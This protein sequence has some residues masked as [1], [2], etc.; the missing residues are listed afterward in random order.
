MGQS[1]SQ[2]KLSG[3]VTL[4][5]IRE[6][7]QRDDSIPESLKGFKVNLL[8]NDLNALGFNISTVDSRGHSLSSEDVCRKIKEQAVP[9][10]EEV[11][12]MNASRKG[13]AM[14]AV[15]QMVK[16]FNKHYGARISIL[17]NPLDPG[18]GKRSI[19]DMC[20]DLYLVSDKL[21]R[22][23]SDRP[24]VIKK[25]LSQEIDKL[26]QYKLKLERQFNHVLGNLASSRGAER[27]K[28]REKLEVAKKLQSVVSHELAQQL[29]HAR[30]NYQTTVQEL[31]IKAPKLQGQLGWAIDQYRLA[32]Y[33]DDDKAKVAA[34]LGIMKQM[35]PAVD[36]CSACIR[37]FGLGVQQYYDMARRN[38]PELQESLMNKYIS[39]MQETKDR[40]ELLQLKKCYELLLLEREKCLSG[41]REFSGPSAGVAKYTDLESAAAQVI[42]ALNAR[43]FPSGTTTVGDVEIQRTSQ[44]SATGAKARATL[45]PS[46]S[47]PTKKAPSEKASGKAPA[48]GSSMA[49]LMKQGKKTLEQ[50]AF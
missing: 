40:D 7:C 27:D 8:A 5:R 50:S 6:A 18:Q 41:P 30:Q 12:M 4:N 38:L 44:P 25:K 20:D 13:E 35:G 33:G 24:D 49:G 31:N 19:S 48:E 16:H 39:L 23:L 15:E 45:A 32:R 29:N 9:D 14:H 37:K 43:R 17:K 28:L 47:A 36:G 2:P 46:T 1:F 21:Y 26:H 42:N 10:V 22:K 3:E 34:L 11:C